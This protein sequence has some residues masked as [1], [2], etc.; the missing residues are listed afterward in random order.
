MEETMPQIRPD[1]I[2]QLRIGHSL[3]YGKVKP[4]DSNKSKHFLYCR[5]I[6]FKWLSNYMFPSEWVTL[7]FLCGASI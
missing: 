4:D 1:V 5:K 6:S 3:G 2:V 7:G